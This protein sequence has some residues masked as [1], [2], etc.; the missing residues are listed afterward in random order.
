MDWLRLL[1][2]VG[3]FLLIFA[4]FFLM[5]SFMGGFAGAIAA[6]GR[7]DRSL[8]YNF[9]IGLIGSVIGTG[10][11]SGINGEWPEEPTGG[12]ILLSFVASIGVA[13]VANSWEKRKTERSDS[14]SDSRG[15]SV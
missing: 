9:N 14:G 10:I 7:E 11:W 12:A 4:G 1:G 15:V 5:V 8:L 2:T 13:L 3:F 6:G